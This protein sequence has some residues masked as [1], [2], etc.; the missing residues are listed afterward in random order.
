[1][2]ALAASL[3]P[4]RARLAVESRGVRCVSVLTVRVLGVIEVETGGEARPVSSPKQ[5]LVLALLVAARGPVSRERLVDALWGDEPPS[6]AAATLMGYVSRL[7]STLGASGID[8]KPEGYRLDADI[9]DAYQFESLIHATGASDDSATLERALELWRGHAFG[10]FRTHP[11]LTGEAHRLEELRAH[12]RIRLASLYLDAGDV[13]RPTSMLE[14]IVADEPLRED[15]WVLLVRALLAC[16]RPP[17]AVRAAQRCRRQLAEIGL[18]P[19]PALV[20]AETCALDQRTTVGSRGTTAEQS[21]VSIG[22][23]RYARRDGLH[24]AYQIVGGGPVDLVVSSYGSISI[25]S[26]WDSEHFSAFVRR[27]GSACRLILYDTRGIGLSDPIKVDA[28]PSLEEQSEDLMAV[29]DDARAKRAVVVGVGDGGPTAITAAHQR[30]DHVVGLVLVN[31][32]ARLTE[33]KD[34]P[35]GIPSERLIANIDMST[36]HA[37]DR[38]TSLVLRNHA[39]SVAGDQLF[40]QWW[41][42]A[43]RRGASPATAAALWRI[44]YGADV[45]GLLSTLSMPTLVIHRRRSRV[46]PMA[47]GAFLAEHIHNS[48]LVEIAGTDQTPFTEGADDIADLI[49]AFA[50]ARSP[51]ESPAM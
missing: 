30:P 14:A 50:T 34:Y 41:E 37:S 47:H 21:A 17:D 48:R 16:G 12:T 46:V 1:M 24:L 43:G 5:R 28:A 23:V 3:H 18:E 22:P 40:R 42:R 6:S 45:R 51:T 7:R 15:A 38:D 11:Y 4:A 20:A 19:S 35:A 49:T 33:A 31:T 39:P 44:R 25:D 26:I 10:E 13:A 9:V 32:F 2:A 8:G 36:D 27:L 29:L